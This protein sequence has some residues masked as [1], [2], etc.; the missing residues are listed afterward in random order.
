[1]AYTARHT[2]S[3]IL[4]QTIGKIWMSEHTYFDSLPYAHIPYDGHSEKVIV[5]NSVH[6]QIF[7]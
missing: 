2:L 3:P 1:M 5:V 6:C 4:G 7:I